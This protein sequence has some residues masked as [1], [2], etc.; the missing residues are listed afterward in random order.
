MNSYTATHYK[1]LENHTAKKTKKHID[2][3]T[4]Q[5]STGCLKNTLTQI[6]VIIGH[7][8]DV[9]YFQLCINRSEL[10]L[11]FALITFP[12]VRIFQICTYGSRPNKL[13]VTVANNRPNSNSRS[14]VLA[15]ILQSHSRT[16]QGP[17]LRYSRRTTQTHSSIFI[18]M[19]TQVQLTFDDF[20]HH[21][22]LPEKR[23]N[24]K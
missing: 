20:T 18:R 9:T 6:T 1:K 14:R 16:F 8:G 4:T 17:H 2:T 23:S 12:K 15:Q 7:F 11:S 21:V 3:T 19:F 5:P 22:R 24:Q 13:S 10:I